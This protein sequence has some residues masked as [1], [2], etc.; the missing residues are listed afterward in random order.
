MSK[1]GKKVNIHERSVIDYIIV[2]RYFFL[3][4]VLGRKYFPALLMLG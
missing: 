2:F 1:K 4:L 3:S